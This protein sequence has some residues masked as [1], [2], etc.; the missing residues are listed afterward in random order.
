MEVKSRFWDPQKV[1][2]SLEWRCPLDRGNKNN[3]KIMR[4]FFQDQILCPLNKR[5]PWMEVSQRRG[6]TVLAFYKHNYSDGGICIIDTQMRYVKLSPNLNWVSPILSGRNLVCVSHIHVIHFCTGFTI[7]I[8]V[9][10]DI[11]SQYMH[12][13]IVLFHCL[14]FTVLLCKG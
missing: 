8:R 1:S 14:T 6:S 10:L 2:L 11:P 7:H 13:S 3:T 4:T 9:M 12:L 5:V